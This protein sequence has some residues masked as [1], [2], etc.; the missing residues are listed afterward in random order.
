MN[1]LLQEQL[2]DIEGLDVI[3]WWPLAIGWWV[4][5]IVGTCLFSVSLFFLVRHLIFIRS[6]KSDTLNK[7]THLERKLSDS[8]ARET[9]MALSEY[10]RRIALKRFSRKE[11]AS[12]VGYAWL[13]WLKAH[14][15]KGFDWEKEGLLLIKVPYAPINS[16]FPADQVRN[17]IQATKNWVC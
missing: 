5:I 3:S 2:N 14:D 17:L 16:Q 15:P 6:W 13:T 12:L 7:L 4:V 8:T 10:L 9:A 1:S 11:C